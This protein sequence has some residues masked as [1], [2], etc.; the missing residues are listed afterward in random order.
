M[1]LTIFNL[2]AHHWNSFFFFFIFFFCINKTTLF[3][4]SPIQMR[5]SFKCWLNYQRL[6]LGVVF[7]LAR[8]CVWP[9]LT[10]RR[11]KSENKNKNSPV[12]GDMNGLRTEWFYSIYVAFWLQC[13]VFDSFATEEKKKQREK[14]QP[15]QV[16]VIL[17]RKKNHRRSFFMDIGS[18]L[19]LCLHFF[20]R[21][22]FRS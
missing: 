2:H 8:I 7:F 15:Q 9:V 4:H 16:D 22:F 21:L 11:K 12:S 1:I 20:D 18:L 17:L 14:K 19:L 13:Y 6:F 5:N 3:T 10:M